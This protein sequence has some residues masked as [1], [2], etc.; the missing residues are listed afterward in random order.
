MDEKLLAKLCSGAKKLACSYFI[1]TLDDLHR[2]SIY[3]QLAF[4]RIVRKSEDMKKIYEGDGCKNWPHTLYIAYLKALGA[5]DNGKIYY[6]LARRVGYATILHERYDR[7]GL[8]AI[9]I[10]ASGQL[11]NLT[12]GDPYIYRLQSQGAHLLKKHKIEPLHYGDWKVSGNMPANAP[13][14]RLSQSAN[15]LSRNEDLHRRVIDSNGIAD[16]ERIFRVEASDYWSQH[17]IPI[18]SSRETRVKYI[19]SLKC[20]LLAINLVAPYQ[21]AYAKSIGDEELCERAFNSWEK[22]SDEINRIIKKWRDNGV[23][24]RNAHESQALIQL[25]N[26]YCM[27]GECKIC[28]V[29]RRIARTGGVIPQPPQL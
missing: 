21:F 4:E 1:A 13:I 23:R 10:G 9:L 25:H 7:E 19:G 24:P 12:E 15:L 20:N 28:P 14:F 26:E 11:D 6:E 27:A 2:L 18:K 17:D 5:N 29:A 16:V 22:L 3:N 8:E